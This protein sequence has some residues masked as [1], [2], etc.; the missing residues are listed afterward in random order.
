MLSHPLPPSL[1][2]SLLSTTRLTYWA[3]LFPVFLLEHAVTTHLLPSPAFQ[4]LLPR[5]EDGKET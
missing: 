2:P 5:S 1:P 4:Q 3:L